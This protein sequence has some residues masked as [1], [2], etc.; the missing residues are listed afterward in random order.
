MLTTLA[1]AALG[2]D[3]VSPCRVEAGAAG[4]ALVSP[5]FVFHLGT[6]DGLRA[7]SWENR[8]TAQRLLLAGAELEVDLG[9][10]GGPLV[11]PVWSEVVLELS[12]AGQAGEAVFRLTSSQ[13]PFV[14]RVTYRW[15]AAVPVLHK[16]VELTQAGP[17]TVT[18]LNV[19][20]GTYRVD[21][22]IADREQ[23]FPAYLG[24]QCFLS[25][26]HPAGWAMAKEGLLV[27]Q[28]HPGV[29]LE[30]GSRFSTMEAV[31]GVAAA[32]AA[33]EAFLR[34]VRSRMRRVQRGHDRPYAIFEPFGARSDG[35]FDETEAFV[36]DMVTKV[37]EGQRE[38]DCRFDLFSID[39]W[40]DHK[41][42]LKRCNPERFPRGLEPILQE[43]KAL[44][45]APGLW[46]DSS[47][48]AWSIG[49][50]PAVQACLN[51]D[52][53]RPETVQQGSWG[54]ASF[55]RA[56]EP[57]RSLYTE[58]FRE[59]IRER[60]VRMLKFDNLAT[61]C[62]NPRH[63]HLPGLYSTEPIVNAVI[64]FLQALDAESPDVFLMLYWGYRS[65]WWLLYGDTLFDSGIGIEAASPSIFPAPY[66]RDSIT[67][68]LD[69]AQRVAADV[70][71]LGKD[72][73]GVW[74]SDWWWNSQV[75]KQRW[76]E[77]FIMD[78]C[79]GSLL[80]QPWSDSAWLSPPERR[81]MATFI[82]LLKA[83]PECFG[84]PRFILG[85]PGQVGPYGYCCTDGRRA[86]LALNNAGWDDRVLTLE[87][88]AAWGLPDDGAWDLVR[89]YPEPA[90]LRGPAAACG[91]R[92]SLAL[93]PFEVML[94]E[95]IPA[96]SAPSLPRPLAVQPIPTAFAESSQR[97]DL[98]ATLEVS[99]PLAAAA[100]VWTP[101]EVLAASAVAGTVL[102]VQ[103]DGSILASGASP[104][105]DT[106]TIRARSRLTGLIT[107]VRLEALPDPSLP[108][109]GPGRA[110]NG[111]F[112]LLEF[113]LART[114]AEAPAALLPVPLTHALASYEQQSHGGWPVAA[115]ID[116]I[117]KTGWSIDPHEGRQHEAVFELATPVDTAAGSL[118][119]FSLEMGDRQHTVGRFRL[120]VTTAPQ[121]LPKPVPSGADK[122][123]IEG[124]VPASTSGGLLVVSARLGDGPHPPEPSN[125]GTY[126]THQ[127]FVDEQP[128]TWTAVLGTA[129]Y[130]SSWQAWRLEVAPSATPR[131]FRLVVE[132]SLKLAVPEALAAYY[133]PR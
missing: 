42:D 77:G 95:V 97:L 130:P 61:T 117:P 73:L 118:L 24:G 84:N 106:Y 39:F 107:G 124:Q 123:I 25:L 3:A 55:C 70:P 67:Q 87:L 86:F 21:T 17:E 79:R 128:A 9:A 99:A 62:C 133:L 105:R 58:A 82:G 31:Y 108:G 1:V 56:T 37:G 38:S 112:S 30:A 6:T 16:V 103:P 53:D 101:V 49:G 66:A 8:L 78:L 44:G 125:I 12:T 54:R 85:D 36:L 41:G 104:D 81:Q 111:N 14:A 127:G 68:K 23:G 19:R 132:S 43:L 47:G 89:W 131:R 126:F 119:T 91:P 33:R 71:V 65:P 109:N 90:R 45:I 4:V 26:A 57:I 113:R 114:P 88:N 59:H 28:Q 80:A 27:L 75:G 18:L 64:E 13:P 20:L 2:Q 34:Q 48:E 15:T 110:A 51:Y 120:A 122:A 74:L 63:D 115:A 96:G 5:D 7:E 102:T 94:I 29:R 32:G 52:L 35:N 92:V 100:T 98:N 69:Q 76:Q 93:R 50:N 11:A 129:T 22:A 60:G 72:S 10:P 40:V 83:R 121:P 116:G 46:I